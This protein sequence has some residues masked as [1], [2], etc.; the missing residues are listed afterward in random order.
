MIKLLKNNYLFLV[1]FLLVILKEPVYRL[2][3][4]EKNI[5]NPTR[6]SFLE[7]DYNKLLEFNNIDYIYESD[8]YNSIV[9]YKDIYNYLNEI[10]IRGGTSE[11]FKK[12]PVIYDNTLV[13]IITSSTK[14]TSIVQLV[15]NNDFRVSVKINDSIGVLDGNLEVKNIDNYSDIKVGDRVYTSGLGN[16]KENIYI[17]E[18]QSIE[19]DKKNI[20]KII[21]IKYDLKIKDI[22]Y[23]QVLKENLWYLFYYL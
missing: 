7:D 20:E 2:F 1:V 18:V 5:Y 19:L 10:T 16:I 17:G 9:L 12:N 21:K 8:Y 11:G 23:V 4:L 6:C 13:G 3:Y 22:D 15:T 14:N